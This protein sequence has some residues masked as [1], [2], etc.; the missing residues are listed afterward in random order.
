MAA[1]RS[2]LGAP[3]IYRVPP[4]LAPTLAGER[5]DVCA[6]VGV[7]ARGP[8]WV[9]VVDE[10]WRADQPTIG[11]ARA[12]RRSVARRVTSWAE[13]VHLYGGLRGPGRLPWAVR[14]FFDQGG[15]E[16]W[17]VRITAPTE[18]DGEGFPNG[19]G[20]VKLP[21]LEGPAPGGVHLIARDEGEWS[22]R[23]RAALG[24]A[25]APLSYV[26]ASASTLSFSLGDA[27]PPGSLV[28]ASFAVGTSE[29][30]FV[31]GL[32][33]DRTAKR[34][35][36]SLSAPWTGA[37]D[38]IVQ[39]D[40]VS[41]ELWLDDGQGIRERHRELGLSALHPR[42]IAT[43]LCHES[44]LAWPDERWV[45]ATLTV[46]A[47]LPALDRASAIA[48]TRGEDRYAAIEVAHFFDDAWDPRGELPGSGIAAI[49]DVP[50][51]ASVV[52]PDLY[53]PQ[54]LIVDESVVDVDLSGSA[55]WEACVEHEPIEAE[56][57]PNLDSLP[58]LIRDVGSQL[59][60]IVGW[61]QKLVGVA[62]RLGVVAL[63]DVPPGLEQ[64]RILAWR[65]N[66]SSS[67][68]A[69]YHPWLRLAR[70]SEEPEREVPMRLG[71]AALAAGIIAR[72][73]LRYGIP[74]GPANELA[75]GVVDVEDRVS[76][77]R[78]DE[79]HPRAINVFLRERDGVRLT[80]A[81][82]LSSDPSLRQLSVRRLMQLLH[83][84]LERQ[85]QWVVFEPNDDRLRERLRDLLRVFL[86]AL[87]RQGAF[88]GASESEAFFIRCDASNNPSVAVERGELLAEI[89]V[90]PAEPLE[91]I[92]LTI[93]RD[94]D[95][96]LE[97][98]PR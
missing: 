2:E 22:N 36:A 62:E 68:A 79:L 73:E 64:R 66:F 85:L 80:A 43:V 1:P 28:R 81:R 69:A 19:A 17:I 76:P 71:P 57:E 78:H 56:Q 14:A 87:F 11:P 54:A 3:G 31:T 8:A 91:F 58:G 51:I 13:F 49:A 30:R 5:L 84:S 29:L 38:Q 24:F 88:R 94:G 72:R 95:G 55:D 92:V 67:W 16:A 41:A 15:V 46:D 7:A 9:P 60:E 50:A 47:S 35:L 10:Q 40:L 70:T 59:A 39:L 37:P 48:F 83:R 65:Q 20:R 82:T 96:Q 93:R 77:R 74:H 25:R 6:F 34:V 63:L 53:H 42:F 97:V 45:E 90:A 89:G 33:V 75:A 61:Q 26:D 21:Y 4:T 98:V 44:E 12:R 32:V 86:R 27:P 18:L 23:M 52:V